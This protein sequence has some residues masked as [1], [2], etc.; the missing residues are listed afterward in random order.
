MCCLL[1]YRYRG[2]GEARG[3]ASDCRHF[4]GNAQ[5]AM[6]R[7]GNGNNNTPHSSRSLI[8]IHGPVWKFSI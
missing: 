3:I 6:K 4:Q 8:G 7:V 5:A 1:A 2:S